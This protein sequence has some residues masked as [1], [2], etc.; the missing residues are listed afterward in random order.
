MLHADFFFAP[1]TTM[2]FRLWPQQLQML[3][4]AVL[5][6]EPARSVISL[7]AAYDHGIVGK[8]RLVLAF[9][10]KTCVLSG[11]VTGRHLGHAARRLQIQKSQNFIVFDLGKRGACAIACECQSKNSEDRAPH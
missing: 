9:G 10:R 8:C 6:L 5:L 11:D 1:M 4:I 3:E 2:L 7:I